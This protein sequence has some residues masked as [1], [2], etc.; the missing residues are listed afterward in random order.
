MDTSFTTATRFAAVQDRSSAAAPTAVSAPVDPVAHVVSTVTGVVSGLLGLVGLGSSASNPA[1]PPAQPPVLFAVLDFVRRELFNST[2]TLNPTAPT[3]NVTT[4]LITGDVNAA[5]ADG[6]PLIFKVTRAPTNGVVVVDPTGA[7]TYTP[8]A[9]YVGADTFTITASDDSYPHLHLLSFLQP[10]FGHEDTATIDVT[11][12]D[13]APAATTD[14]YST[15]EDNTLTVHAANGLLANDTDIDHNALSAAKV[16][17]AAHGTVVVNSDGSF[18]YAPAAD[19]SGPDSFSYKASDGHLDSTATVTITVTAVNDPPT[20]VNDTFNTSENAALTN[21]VLTNDTDPDTAH[22]A[23]S[24]TLVSGPAHA[25]SFTLNADG[26]FTYAPVADYNGPD[27][28]S[29]KASDGTA[30]SNTGTVAITVTPAVTNTTPVIHEVDSTVVGQ[31][32]QFTVNIDATD[33][34]G[35]PISY[36]PSRGT[37][38]SNGVGGYTLI[39]DGVSDVAYVLFGF[40]SDDLNITGSTAAVVLLAQPRDTTVHN[41]VM[42]VHILSAVAPTSVTDLNGTTLTPVKQTTNNPFLIDL[43]YDLPDG[44][45]LANNSLVVTYI[46]QGVTSKTTISDPDY[47]LLISD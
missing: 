47:K 34:H 43:F 19:Y 45:T 2:P 17:D 42:T 23:L 38:S 30:S 18:S 3:T 40:T 20:A 46:S 7:Y 14:S 4:G 1:D 31:P 27:S 28:F 37:L 44:E 24:A 36:T 16:S 35:E 25:A 9:G 26:S 41:G 21:N 39:P 6:D 32:D 10:G 11:L 22:S 33:A 8:N 29:Y 13:H 12:V 15:T 5:D